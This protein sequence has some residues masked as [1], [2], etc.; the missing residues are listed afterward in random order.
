MHIK[1][2]RY[3]SFQ[4]SIAGSKQSI[5]IL[6]FYFIVNFV[7]VLLLSQTRSCV[8]Q[9]VALKCFPVKKFHVFCDLL[10]FFFCLSV[11]FY[12]AVTWTVTLELSYTVKSILLATRK[13]FK[14][15]D[16]FIWVQILL[17]KLDMLNLLRINPR[18]IVI[19][20]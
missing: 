20:R 3:K 7:T 9:K 17:L 15:L 10:I 19:L 11:T 14:N 12:F 4:F 1:S 18:K 2:K 8:I 16:I 5:N 13:K 6:N